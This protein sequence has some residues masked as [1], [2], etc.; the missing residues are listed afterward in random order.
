MLTSKEK[1][2]YY[3]IKLYIDTYKYSPSVRELRDMCCLNSPATIHSYLRK[4]KYK[5]YIDWQEKKPRTISIIK[6]LGEENE[7]SK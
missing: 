7:N 1:A 6:E 3:N 2:L 5:G 4:L